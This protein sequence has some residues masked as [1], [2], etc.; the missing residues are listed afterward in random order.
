GEVEVR[1]ECDDRSLVLEESEE[2]AQVGSL[3]QLWRQFADGGWR[4]PGRP[5]DL[6]DPVA[7]PA[8]VLVQLRL[9][10]ARRHAPGPGLEHA[11]AQ[12]SAEDPFDERCR[13]FGRER[14][15]QFIPVD[16]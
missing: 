5:E 11:F 10:P 3:A 9:E 2:G 14:P 6:A 7:R 13:R 1:A 4:E 8:L 12:E 15:S 16:P